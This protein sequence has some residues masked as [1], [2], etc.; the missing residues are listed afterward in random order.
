MASSF[1]AQASTLSAA[2]I[3][4][5]NAETA[6]A[7]L[8]AQ[9]IMSLS[10]DSDGDGLMES[11]A[12]QANAIAPVGGGIPPAV[13]GAPQLDPYGKTIGYCVQSVSIN[14]TP[15]FAIVTPGLDSLFQTSCAQALA[16][17]KNGDDF[18]ITYNSSQIQGSAT[19]KFFGD[20]VIDK[21]SLDALPTTDLY[22]GQ[23]RLIT[24]TNQLWRWNGVQWNLVGSPWAFNGNDL[25]FN[26]GNVAIGKVA[27]TA[28]LDVVG[29][30]LFTGTVQGATVNATGANGYQIAGTTVIDGSRNLVNINNMTFQNGTVTGNLNVSG[31]TTTDTLSTTNN[32][33]VGGTLGVTGVLTANGGISTTTVTAS[34][35]L[36]A[37]S[38]NITNGL[39]AASLSAS[40]ATVSGALSAG[41]ISTG[42]ITASSL[43][44]G[45]VEVIGTLT[46]SDGTLTNGLTSTG[47]VI[48]PFGVVGTP[49]L[50]FAGNTNTGIYSSAT[51]NIDF[52]A[53]GTRILNVGTSGVDVKSGGLFINGTQVIS[54]ARNLT[55]I[56]TISSGAITST[57]AIQG[58]TLTS[59]VETGTAPLT[60]ASTTLVTNLNADLLDGQHGSYYQN[61][62]NINAG[63][64]AV[65][66]GGTGLTSYTTGD[67]IYASG[68]GTLGKLADVATGNVLLSG[69]VG[70]APAYG[71]VGLTTHV[72]GTLPVANGGT[73]A[74]TLTSNGVLYGNATGAIQASAAGTSGQLLVANGS[75]VPTFVSLSGDATLASTGAITLANTAVTAGSYG[76]AT[77]VPTFTVDSKGRLTAAGSVAVTPAWANITGKPTTIAGYGITDAQGLDSDLTA[78]AGLGT[79]GIIVRSGAGTAV[80]RTLTAG[81]TK[82][83]VTNGDGV[84]GNPTIDVNEANLTLN[85][86]GGTLGV[87]KGG[88]GLTATTQGGIMY[89]S[90]AAGYAM[91]GAGTAGQVLTSNGTGAPTWTTA[92]NTNTAST[93]VQRDASGNFSAGT[94]TATGVNLSTGSALPGD[95]CTTAGALMVASNGELVFCQEDSNTNTL[96]GNGAG[97][98]NTNPANRI[99]I[100]Y[101]AYATTDNSAVIGNNS[102]TLIR[103]GADN[104]VSLGN[105]SYRFT[106]VYATNG[107]IQTS[108]E[109]LKKNIVTIEPDEAES[110]L[111]KVRSVRYDWKSP[112]QIIT[113]Q[114]A[115]Q[116]RKIGVIAQEILPIMPETVSIEEAGEHLMGVNYADMVPMTIAAINKHTVMLSGFSVNSNELTIDKTVLIKQNLTAERINANSAYIKQLDVTEK[117]KAKE[118]EAEKI[119]AKKLNSGEKL[120]NYD[121]LLFQVMPGAIYTVQLAADDGEM[122]MAQVTGGMN[123]VSI[124]AFQEQSMLD[125][126][127]KPIMRPQTIN[128]IP[129]GDS[130]G[131]ST[132][133]KL[134]KATWLR[135]A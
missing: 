22:D 118:I 72:S 129:L 78:L 56:G 80:T 6:T 66:R 119:L 53:N 69:G 120:L 16:G 40:T 15:V 96:V 86:I 106:A 17:N 5:R 10:S 130:V 28:A 24:S 27:A 107:T 31:T 81:S 13:S 23:I 59:T 103:S 94:I 1:N 18:L 105:A 71:K 8:A 93:I 62:S 87:S 45:N 55:N 126:D 131:V 42:A 37:N 21:N 29:S 33:T 110:L 121:D 20:P 2:Q 128:L 111:S 67:I 44:S 25:Y 58:T 123:G 63:T 109:R 11:P 127:G 133:G 84:S 61:A 74:T 49:T 3:E 75:G 52:S 50:T 9:T 125:K 100:G 79:T 51:N 89:G 108:D 98:D 124:K 76:S 102:L 35:M 43:K 34:G 97:V 122:M 115:S 134:V 70:V 48:V 132:G 114:S 117:L 30:G 77:N 95:V 65:A 85:N 88:T 12:F 112:N 64:L 82:V 26:D 135:A 92:T 57:G 60:V 41:S 36:T 4:Q 68:A 104:S 7:R 83:T 47:A 38:A 91:S 19:R 101:G 54:S 116:G 39:S 99:A 73:G 32:A 14:T 90:S 46:V 113:A